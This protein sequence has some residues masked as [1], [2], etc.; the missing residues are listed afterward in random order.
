MPSK[1]STTYHGT[2][3][4]ERRGRRVGYG[5]GISV[6]CPAVGSSAKCWRNKPVPKTMRRKLLCVPLLQVAK[7]W[8]TGCGLFTTKPKNR[9]KVGHAFVEFNVN[10]CGLGC[11][12]I[13]S[14][15]SLL[16]SIFLWKTLCNFHLA[17]YCTRGVMSVI[18]TYCMPVIVPVK[19]GYLL[20]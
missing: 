12:T 16:C 18:S 6:R 19:N 8:P 17:S 4:T 20:L 11:K 5:S 10:K 3:E 7:T 14:N 13:L 15:N 2:S 1:R 9:P